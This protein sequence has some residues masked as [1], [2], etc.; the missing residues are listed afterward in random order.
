MK[1]STKITTAVVL[2]LGIIGATGAFAAKS[3][4]GDHAEHAERA[5]GFIAKKLDLD[6]NQTQAL[7]NLKDEVLVAKNA[8]HGET[9]AN[10]EAVRALIEADSFDQGK[11]LELINARTASVN[12]AAPNLVIALG[13][14][15]DSL[16]SEQKQEILDF[17]S[18]RGDRKR[19]RSRH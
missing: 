19:G 18:K 10:Q 8:V 7:A 1:K 11:A 4:K 14:F 12:S 2:S 3:H 16:N 17:M 5:V 15:M 6:E 9:G 13:T